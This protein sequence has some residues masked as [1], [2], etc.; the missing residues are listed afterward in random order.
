MN[1]V[2]G[3]DGGASK[4]HCLAATQDG[5]VLGMG[6]G[7]PSNH[8]VS[9]LEAAMAEVAMAVDQA[10]G[11]AS[12]DAASLGMFCL[13]GADLPEDLTLLGQAITD[14]GLCQEV[15][16]KNDTW[17]ALHSGL[18]RSWGVVVVCGTG[19][20][21]AGRGRDGQEIVFPGLGRI[22]GDW[23]GAADISQEIVR[24]VMR[25]WDGRGEP[26]ALSQAV[27][28]S[29]DLSSPAELLRMLY[30]DRLGPEQ[31]LALA[32][33][34]F[35]A[36]DSGDAVARALVKA[37]G[38][39]VA[40]TAGALIRRLSLA[41]QNVEVVLAGSIFKA[42]GPLLIETVE[43]ALLG[44]APRASV[45]LPEVEP[46]VGALLLA[47][48]AMGTEVNPTVRLRI[49]ASLPEQLTIRT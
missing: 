20:N 45:V 46:V 14:L 29:L 31:L 26:T 9:G 11:Q 16:V 49:R 5:R 22:S 32:P 44:L 7:G 33:L 21:A 2:L 48:Q 47:L 43:Q 24:L 37:V 15:V 38:T 10:L 27:L 36:A 3:I 41:D 28:D 1:C 35:Q 23:G 19:T 30:H 13:A 4:T 12:I 18:S 34:V 40:T 39:E 25:A 8:Q 17:A 6:R 42:E